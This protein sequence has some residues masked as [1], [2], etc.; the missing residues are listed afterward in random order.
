V[1]G[2]VWVAGGGGKEFLWVTEGLEGRLGGG[3]GPSGPWPRLRWKFN[4]LHSWVWPV[5]V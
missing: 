2:G 3:V 5:F 4:F 1:Q